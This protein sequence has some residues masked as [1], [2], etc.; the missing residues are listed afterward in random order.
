MK[1][2]AETAWHHE[3]D[4]AFME[5]L[6]EELTTKS[7]TDYIKLHLTLD[8]DEY[9]DSRHPSYKTLKNWMLSDNQWDKIISQVRKSGKKLMLLFNDTES[10]RFGMKYN[11]ELIEIHSVCLNDVH[12]L[13]KLKTNLKKTQKVVL[14]VGGSSLYEIENAISK[15]NHQEIILMFGFQNYPTNYADINLKKIR[16]IMSLYPQLKHGYADHTSWD[17][18]N[19]ELITLLVSAVGM[20]YIEKHVTIQQGKERC[21]WQS[22]ISIQ[23]FNRIAEKVKLIKELN[24]DGLLKLNTAEKDYSR[25]GPMKKACVFSKDVT[26][27]QVFTKNLIEFKRTSETS[28]LSQIDVLNYIGTEIM[29]NCE[30]NTVIMKKHFQ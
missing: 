10:I 28:D 19:N 26:T 14:G 13:D 8:L 11:P 25:F 21:D 15:L 23:T 18:E 16:K 2:I 5:K 20:D 29:A 1:L 4:Y 9:M 17:D 3:G 27:G 30:K 6:I 22:A 7:K 24:G 12:L